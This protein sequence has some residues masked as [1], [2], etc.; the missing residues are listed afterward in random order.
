MDVLDKMHKLNY[1]ELEELKMFE[2]KYVD[3]LLDE[4]EGLYDSVRV[5]EESLKNA[6]INMMQ[7]EIA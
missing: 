5:K 4:R 1:D 7:K 2:F 6:R 3:A